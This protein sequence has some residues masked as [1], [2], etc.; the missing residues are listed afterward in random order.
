MLKQK[1]ESWIVALK[2]RD[3]EGRKVFILRPVLYDPE[4]FS[5]FDSIKS[6]MYMLMLAS[7][8]EKSQIAGCIVINDSTNIVLK[9]CYSPS[10]IMNF[11]KWWNSSLIFRFQGLYFVNLPTFARYFAELGKSLLSGKL[12]ERVHVLKKG[13]DA[14]NLID[15][16]ILPKEYGGNLSFDDAIDDFSN[17]YEKNREE[18]V[19]IMECDIDWSNVPESWG[20]ENEYESV[21]SFRRLEID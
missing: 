16:A 12:Q 1:S 6:M 3:A 20:G 11:A 14:R 21:G 13:E 18:L 19:K 7:F 10:T 2:H 17:L 15:P 9:H 4:V 8:E 5:E